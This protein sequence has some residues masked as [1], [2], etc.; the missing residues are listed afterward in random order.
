MDEIT[1]TVAENYSEDEGRSIA[2]LDPKTLLDLGIKPGDH[3]SLA[4]T[5]T[6]VV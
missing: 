3:S 1:R 5:H 4:K 6:S 2:R